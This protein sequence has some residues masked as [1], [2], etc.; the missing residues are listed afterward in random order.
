MCWC[1]APLHSHSVVGFRV[2]P[3]DFVQ[4]VAG[5]LSRLHCSPLVVCSTPQ[6]VPVASAPLLLLASVGPHLVP[7]VLV[8]TFHLL[9]PRL[10]ET[11]SRSLGG[12]PHCSLP[13]LPR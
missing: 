3:P 9:P 6:S 4:S 11:H 13:P 5:L 12:L 1:L 10:I 2:H 8:E 7:R